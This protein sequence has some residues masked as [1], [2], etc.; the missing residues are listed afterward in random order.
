MNYM[1]IYNN[2]KSLD[3]EV[4]TK[5]NNHKDLIK[6]LLK[7]KRNIL[8]FGC[9]NGSFDYS[10]FNV[11]GYDIDKENKFAKFH[12]LEEINKNYDIVV[13]NQVIEHMNHKEIF[14]TINFLKN[15]ANEIIFVF[16]NFWFF[17]AKYWDDYT[18][19]RPP[20]TRDIVIL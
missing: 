5:T 8:D 3:E 7:S 1:K 14:E 13:L 12:R 6:Y 18:H 9:G 2:R 19:K 20:S 11:D 15:I 16:P 10:G 4:W 17:G